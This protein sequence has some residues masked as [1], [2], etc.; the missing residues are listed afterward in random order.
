MVPPRQEISASS[1]SSEGGDESPQKKQ[2]KQATMGLFFKHK[3]QRGRSKKTS[4][5]SPQ[6]GTAAAAVAV[7]GAT[8]VEEGTS[9]E[10]DQG[11]IKYNKKNNKRVNWG[12]GS[13]KERMDKAMSDWF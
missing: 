9:S 13:H 1:L 6:G 11:D 2:Y 5:E 12:Q 4:V 8:T 7:T 3:C 10:E